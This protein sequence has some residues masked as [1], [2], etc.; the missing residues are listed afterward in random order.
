MISE[1]CFCRAQSCEMLGVFADIVCVS[2]TYWNS[3]MDSRWNPQSRRED[4]CTTLLLF[5]LLQCLRHCANF[6]LLVMGLDWG[7]FPPASLSVPC[8]YMLTLILV[9]QVFGPSF[10]LFARPFTLC[11]PSPC[12]GL[13]GIAEIQLNVDNSYLASCYTCLERAG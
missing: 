11:K 6:P 13:V 4:L 3:L 7:I 8:I 9:L 10:V 1:G 5:R 12:S 2:P